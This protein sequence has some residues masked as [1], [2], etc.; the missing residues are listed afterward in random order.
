M[1]NII[2]CILG[3]KSRVKDHYSRVTSI[4]AVVQFYQA[5]TQKILLDTDIGSDID[6]AVCLAYLLAN[7]DCELLGVTTVTG[8]GEQRAQLVSALCEK[9]GMKV[10]IFVGAQEPLLVE[11][12]QARSPQNVAIA[13]WK[14]G[15]EF[16][17]G[18]AIGFMQHTIRQNPGEVILLT[19]GPLTNAALLFK[20]DPEI[21]T[22]LKGLVMMGGV[23]EKDGRE[24]NV[25]LDPHATA[26]VYRAKIKY[27]RSI[28]LDVT[29]QVVMPAEEVRK[30]FQTPLLRLVLNLAEVWFEE[31]TEIVFHDPL[32]AATIF[33]DGICQFKRGQVEVELCDPK[34][35]GKT[36]WVT[37]FDGSHEVAITVNPERFFEHFFSVF[38]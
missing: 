15:S 32:A 25:K 18:E 19:I 29:K 35:S 2:L 1:A 16:P 10:P 33:Q 26:I 30:R 28:G 13:S 11:Q 31:K 23:F 5:M 38:S 24:W 27:H 17:V 9:A 37:K 36:H 6:D 12:L 22:L 3:F 21:Q 8:E 20:I 34:T 4:P 14:H 7:P